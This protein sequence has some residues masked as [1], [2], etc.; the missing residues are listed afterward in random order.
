MDKFDTG[1]Q[2]A[3]Q[4]TGHTLATEPPAPDT[5]LAHV[6]AFAAEHGTDAVT[7]DVIAAAM[8]GQL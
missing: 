5:P 4:V 6:L 2:F 1:L 3:L 8:A 7:E